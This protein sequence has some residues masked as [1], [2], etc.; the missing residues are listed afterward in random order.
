M[1]V[2]KFSKFELSWFWGPIT[3]CAD[4]WLKWILKQ[5]C[6][7]CWD[8]FNGMLHATCTQGNWGDS[9]LL[10]VGSQITNLTPDPSFG[11]NFC[12][13]CPNGSWDIYIL[14]AFQWYKE[15]FNLMNFD[16]Y[17]CSMKIQESIG[18]PT[19]KVGAHLGMWRFI[20]SHSLALPGACNVAHGIILGL[21]LCKPLPWL[22]A[23]S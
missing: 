8:I 5:S 2:S 19:S 14:R 11:H 20:P 22:W 6:N 7:L 4:L 18:T 21:H 9:W 17:N 12:F 15:R 13:R 1:G 10:V 23:Q 3:L 16:P